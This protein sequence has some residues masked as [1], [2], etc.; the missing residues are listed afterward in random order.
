MQKEKAA[1]GVKGALPDGLDSHPSFFDSLPSRSVFKS[2]SPHTTVSIG[3]TG[4]PSLLVTESIV[5]ASIP[6]WF[7]TQ[8]GRWTR[9][10]KKLKLGNWLKMK[11]YFR[12]V[13]THWR[14][15]AG[16]SFLSRLSFKCHW[17]KPRHLRMEAKILFCD[18]KFRFLI[19]HAFTESQIPDGVQGKITF[20]AK[21]FPT[22][23]SI[24]NVFSFPFIASF[25]RSLKRCITNDAVYLALASQLRK[26]TEVT[27]D[28]KHSLAL[29]AITTQTHI[30]LASIL[31]FLYSGNTP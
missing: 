19:W 17:W 25:C 1:L 22:K 24:T 9:Y 21:L 3:E 16:L 18:K 30:T 20:I 2:L 23:Q 28:P 4:L 13:D 11:F 12:V 31:P 7:A 26:Q 10:S 29:W 14:K 15:P 27:N 5:K 8:G 6:F